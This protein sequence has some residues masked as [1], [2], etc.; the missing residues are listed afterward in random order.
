MRRLR[1]CTGKVWY[2]SVVWYPVAEAMERE[3]IW[4]QHSLICQLAWSEKSACTSDWVLFPT[5]HRLSNQTNLTHRIFIYQFSIS[6]YISAL[7]WGEITFEAKTSW[8]IPVGCGRSSFNIYWYFR[9]LQQNTWAAGIFCINLCV[10]NLLTFEG[11]AILSCQHWRKGLFLTAFRVWLNQGEF[12]FRVS[13][14]NECLSLVLSQAAVDIFS[15]TH[16]FFF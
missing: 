5:L 13:S 2:M 6:H 3:R 7:I 4:K 15:R 11:C 1:F 14:C 10:L 12:C 9:L 16:V 8:P